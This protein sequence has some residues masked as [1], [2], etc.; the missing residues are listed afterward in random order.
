MSTDGFSVLPIRGSRLVRGRL[1]SIQ[2]FFRKIEMKIAILGDIHGNLHALEAV[3]K[4]IERL[5]GDRVIV[6][7]DLINR[8]PNSVAVLERLAEVEYRATL[9]NHD[10]LVRMWIDRDEN[11]PR[12]WFDDPFWRSTALCTEA[13]A[14][15]GWIDALRELP[16]AIEIAIDGAPRVLISHGSPRHYRE[17]YAVYLPEEKFREVAQQFPADLYIGSHTHRPF[18]S[19][20][21]GRRF[22]N[23]GA[24][25]APFDGNAEAKYLVLELQ[26]GVWQSQFR[27]VP[28]DQKG[29]LAAFESSGYLE[30]GGLSAF[31]FYEELRLSRPLF[32]PFWRWAAAN[33]RCC[34][35]NAWTAFQRQFSSRC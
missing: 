10:D 20:I 29:A 9:G 11:I 31:I 22:I 34:D 8:G 27:C 24:V 25:G 19:V 15:A 32:D 30:N 28:Y 17:G 6:N 4:D 7:G 16:M 2:V 5:G 13:L 12:E 33:Q 35:W 26:N 21:A 18:D 23:T 1:K 14:A 3:L